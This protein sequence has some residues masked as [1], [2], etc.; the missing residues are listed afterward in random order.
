M[1]DADI[2]RALEAPTTQKG[3]RR[4]ILESGLP[5]RPISQA[6]SLASPS[7]Y[8]KGGKVK[9][10]GWAKVH[11][12]ERVLSRRAAHILGGKGRVKRKR[13]T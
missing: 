7:E 13:R 6:R 9:K 3:M 1:T 2:A 4:S 12:G 5:F 11:K 10:S 8:S